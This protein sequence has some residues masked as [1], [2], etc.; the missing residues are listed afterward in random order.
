VDSFVVKPEPQEIVAVIFARSCLSGISSHYQMA[1]KN[2]IAPAM[3]STTAM[4]SN[5]TLTER[6]EFGGVIV[7]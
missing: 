2:A 5:M 1:R 3:A 4:V 6:V 7:N